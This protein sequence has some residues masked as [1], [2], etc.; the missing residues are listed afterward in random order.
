CAFQTGH[1]PVA[2]RAS[3]INSACMTFIPW[4]GFRKVARAGDPFGSATQS[5]PNG[6]EATNAP[7]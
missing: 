7:P 2:L 6:P 1:S 4:C 3:R 5:S